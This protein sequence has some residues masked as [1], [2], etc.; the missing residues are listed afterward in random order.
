MP[1]YEYQ[2]SDC[3]RTF[4]KLQSLQERTAFCPT[5][6]KEARKVMS[7]SVGYVMKE[8]GH[9]GGGRGAR[10]P[11]SCCGQSSPCENPKRCCT[12]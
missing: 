3:G 9:G 1:I 5:C 11:G 2:C 10:D 6:G 4:E 8:T 12:K 7:A